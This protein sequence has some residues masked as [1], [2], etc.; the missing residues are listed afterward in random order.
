MVYLLDS[1][2]A[3]VL[4]GIGLVVGKIK[5]MSKVDCLPARLLHSRPM[6]IPELASVSYNGVIFIKP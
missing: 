3:G 4:R 1:F 5:L 2:S 6:S